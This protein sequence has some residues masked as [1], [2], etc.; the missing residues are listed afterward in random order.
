MHIYTYLE[1]L[2]YVSISTS[3]CIVLNVQNM[4][5]NQKGVSD[6]FGEMEMYIYQMKALNDLFLLAKVLSSMRVHIFIINIWNQYTKSDQ[7]MVFFCFGSPVKLVKCHLHLSGS[8]PS[9]CTL[10]FFAVFRPRKCGDVHHDTFS[11]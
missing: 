6:I 10:S 2:L 5:E 3:C 9:K 7:T 4:G 8:H 1:Y 11:S